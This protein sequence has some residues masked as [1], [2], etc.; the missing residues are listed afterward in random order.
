MQKSF[1]GARFVALKWQR[2]GHFLAL[3]TVKK[4]TE[5]VRDPRSVGRCGSFAKERLGN[6]P[7]EDDGST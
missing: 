7:S 4:N 3:L 5:I 2:A 6:Q 1:A